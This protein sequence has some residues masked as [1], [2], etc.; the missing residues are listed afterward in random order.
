M[1][2]DYQT[3]VDSHPHSSL[4]TGVYRI[5]TFDCRYICFVTFT[6]GDWSFLFWK[7]GAW[8]GA[9]KRTKKRRL[10]Q[11]FV[12]PFTI[13][14]ILR[15]RFWALNCIKNANFFRGLRPLTP[16]R[17]SAPGPRWGLRP[18]PEAPVGARSVQR[19][20]VAWHHYGFD[21]LCSP[22]GPDTTFTG[23]HKSTRRPWLQ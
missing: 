3:M 18:P 23:P 5:L 11:V 19:T 1:I 13:F 17:G 4:P 21:S 6:F 14:F 22:G 16:T 10:K 20:S 12:P 8:V 15:W 7:Y 9:Q 2:I